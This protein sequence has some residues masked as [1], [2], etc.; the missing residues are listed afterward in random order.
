M[1]I[2]FENVRFAYAGEG[3]ETLKGVTA[4]FHAADVTLLMG[5]SGCG[6]STLLYLAAGIY[7]HGAGELRGGRIT[8]EGAAPDSL[9]L[10][11]RCGL[12]GMMFQNPELQF[13]MDTVENELIF[14]LE[15]I[16]TPV[17]QIP[18]AIED[19]LR[20]CGI[21]HQRTRTLLSLSGGERQKVMLACLTALKPR[22]LLLDEPFANVDDASART[23]VQKLGQLHREFGTG[24]LAV[25]HRLENWLPVV[26][27]IRI[28]DGGTMLPDRMRTE[29]MDVRRLEALGLDIPGEAYGHVRRPPG[30]ARA[31]VLSIEQLC[32]K[33]GDSTILD[34]LSAS[35]YPGTI[36]AITGESGCGKSSL[37]G[38]L[39]G[40]YSYSGRILLEGRDLRKVRRRDLGKIGFVTQSPQDQFVSDTVYGEVAVGL[41][42]GKDAPRQTEEIL[43]EIGL[44]RYRD[45]SAYMLSQGQ[46]R[47]LGVAA[48][49]VYD[50][51]VLVCDEPTYAQDRRGTRA[52]MERLSKLSAEKNVA[53]IFSTHDRRLAHEYAH[54]VLEMKGGRLFAHTESNL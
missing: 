11:E 42:G 44:W 38:A 47:R 5:P 3:A 53:L 17:E 34:G 37:F 16:C 2:R 25:D 31:P 19:A 1:S 43:R 48:L 18:D 24:I 40:L 12:V 27:C 52:V 28:L 10:P 54:E 30:A 29:N 26:D 39:S 36:Y 51:R 4:E 20:F 32:V 23:I 41:R 35:F 9:Q 33:R 15:N 8:V 50:C 49:M 6:K 45:V 46:Q 22:W 7:P 14:C 21:G 13:C